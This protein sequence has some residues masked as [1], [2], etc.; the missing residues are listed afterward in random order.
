MNTLERL[1]IRVLILLVG[2]SGSAYGQTGQSAPE[3]VQASGP[4]DSPPPSPDRPALQHRNP[5][6]QVMRDD[7]MTISFP[8]SPE[9]DQN[10]TVQ[11]DGYIS[12]KN[13]GSIYIQGMT[14]PEIVE[15]LKKAYSK[16]LHDPII[17]VDLTDFQKPYF[18]VSG[19]VG[20]PGQYDLRHD[21]TVS[22][23]I[24]AAGGFLPTAKTQVFVY[25]RISAGWVEVKKLSLKDLLNGKNVNEDVQM[26]PGD[27]IFVPEKFITNFRKYVPYSL[28]LYLQPALSAL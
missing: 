27:M 26:Q 2:V 8:L 3:T 15:T 14:V 13:I 1:A 20:K 9:L 10:V 21:T 25:H 17:T 28:G 12:L 19:Q 22:E 4:S 18:I 6:Y 7:A 16:V 11:P 23:A 24:A 5:R